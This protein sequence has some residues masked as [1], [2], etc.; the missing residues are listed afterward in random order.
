MSRAASKPATQPS[1]PPDTTNRRPIKEQ[2]HEAVTAN[3]VRMV[4]DGLKGV[5]NLADRAK[6][7]LKKN[8]IEGMDEIADDAANLLKRLLVRGISK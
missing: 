8:G 6:R 1:G 3:T 5:D 4:R 7:E 2:L